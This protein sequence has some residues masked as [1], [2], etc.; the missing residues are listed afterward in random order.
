MRIVIVG[1]GAA[2]QNLAGR[3]CE[4]HHDVVVIDRHPES[5]QRITLEMDAL[6]IEGEGAS[7]AVL[8]EAEIGKAELIVAVTDRDEV[9]ILSCM[10]ARKVGVKHTVA[11][12]AE[13]S[14]L[15][16][17]HLDLQ[18]LGVDRAI[19][20][21]EE[22]A[23]EIFDVLRLPG[24]LEVAQL[25]EGKINA[26]GA[27]TPS[28]SPVLDAPLKAFSNEPW[29]QRIRFIGL[30]RNRELSI[31]HG[32]TQLRA[33]DEVYFALRPEDAEAFLDWMFAGH[34]SHSEKVVIAGCGDLGLSLALRLEQT[35]LETV[36]IEQDRKRA[37]VC[38]EV[39]DHSLVINGNASDRST[40]KEI[41]IK[42]NA[43]FVA[44]T[45]DDELNIVSCVLAKELGAN[46]TIA[47][48]NKAEYVPIINNLSLLDCV[49]SPHLSM[50]RA[51]LRFVRGKNVRD[52][53]FFSKLPGELLEVAI[54]S[55]SRWGGLSLRDVN[56]PKG[57]I[58]AAVQRGSD[59]FVPTGELTLLKNDRLVI[60]CLPATIGKLRSL[61][62][63]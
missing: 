10:Y 2:G 4:M 27:R 36:L 19:N 59:G 40:L 50:I 9:N 51:I 63:K 38:S 14:Y 13:K 20:H 41:G 42:A 21:K 11:R 22:C 53:A 5:L 57:A 55:E 60:Y 18:A 16:S 54:S 31:P 23:R 28:H 30:V 34:R 24:T 37:E 61:F 25:L 3:L 62:R 33:G 49:V 52:V 45:G 58:V 7:P 35:S 48:I 39:L 17:R 6:T 8:D 47:Q 15:S 46:F 26:I 1:A 44:T 29:F 43:A 56:L 12:I 32:E